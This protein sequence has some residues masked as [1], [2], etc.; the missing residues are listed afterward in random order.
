MSSIVYTKQ[1]HLL[2][3]DLSNVILHNQKY[4]KIKSMTNS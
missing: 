2:E 4:D 1:I 3:T